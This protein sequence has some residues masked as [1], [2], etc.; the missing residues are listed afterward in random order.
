MSDT[1]DYII[2]GSGINSLVCAAII[3]KTGKRV[4]ILERNDRIGGC[5]RTEELTQPGFRH[6]VMSSWHPLFLLSPAYAEL[7]SDLEARGLR[8]CH[9]T[10]PTA[11]L[12]ADDTGFVLQTN[13]TDN[14]RVMNQLSPG[15]GDRFAAAM[16]FVEQNSELTF[17]TLGEQ[18]WRASYFWK[19]LKHFWRRG[20]VGFSKDVQRYAESARCWLERD[21]KS[22]QTAACLSP[23]VL[24]AGLS[25]DSVFSSHMAKVIAFSLEAVGTPIVEGGSD[26]LLHAFERLLKDY[27]AEIFT[28]ADVDEILVN[29]NRAHGARSKS[30]QTFYARNAVICSVTPKQLYVD[31]LRRIVIPD[32][33]RCG[34]REFR[35]GLAD[36]QIHLALDAR[37]R[38]KNSAMDDVAMVHLQEDNAGIVRAINEARAGFLPNN[39]TIVVGQ[40]CALDPS[41][42]PEGKSILWIQLQELPSR[43]KG[44]A[45]GEIKVPDSGEWTEAVKHSYAE[46]I[47]SRLRKHI[48][49]LDE[50]MLDRA[51]LS[52]S[53]LTNLNINLVGGDPY[54]GDCAADQFLFW[55]PL[56]TTKNHSTPIKRL[57]HIGAST[58]PGPGLGGSSGYLVAKMLTK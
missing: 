38:W 9:T 15:D 8:Y 39:A 57:Y 11:S 29:K 22:P 20:P 5:I 24:H 25:P 51:V 18:L 19:L 42:A 17:A 44:D 35:H 45:A 3:A 58:H 12:R 47:I 14:V 49:N 23:W 26:G 46:R 28:K 52:P 55:R 16:A 13:R 48:E 53:D 1:F 27:G 56:A 40:P 54:G 4:A 30:Q 33:V 10:Q 43:I 2:V 32:K 21:I 41:R 37:P 7:A 50:I 36:M 34:A 6:D 31:L